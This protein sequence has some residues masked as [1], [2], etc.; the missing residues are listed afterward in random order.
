MHTMLDQLFEEEFSAVHGCLLS[1]EAHR[2]AVTSMRLYF[3]NY[4]R[5]PYEV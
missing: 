2:S 5:G 3:G 4:G 1:Q